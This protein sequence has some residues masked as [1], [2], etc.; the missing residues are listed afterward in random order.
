MDNER[1]LPK[2]Q[3]IH[4]V[5]KT[6]TPGGGDPSHVETMHPLCGF[7]QCCEKCNTASIALLLV[8]GGLLLAAGLALIFTSHIVVGIVLIGLAGVCI[9][10]A[11]VLSYRANT[12]EQRERAVNLEQGSTGSKRSDHRLPPSAPPS[13]NNKEGGQSGEQKNTKLPDTPPERRQ[14]T[15]PDTPPD[16]PPER[17]QHTPPQ[18]IDPE[19]EEVFF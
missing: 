12:L 11:A 16:T 8:L 13:I 6:P 3:C 4:S 15:L 7:L 5:F 1:V 14:Y 18:D 19:E 2:N 10:V 9:T 17:R